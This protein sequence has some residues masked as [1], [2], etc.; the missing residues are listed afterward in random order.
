M[1]KRTIA[2][3]VM[4]VLGFS[5]INAP[6]FAASPAESFGVE[7]NI[8]KGCANDSDGVMCI[9]RLVVIIMS[10]CIG[11]LAVIGITVAGI[12]YLTAGGNED[13]TK[14]AKRRLY[15]IVIGL[16]AYVLIALL[17]GWLI[18]NFVWP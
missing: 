14:K 8:L 6:V 5:S 18:P 2:L 17:L 9:L 3:V 4:L 1:L 10:V 16:L 12:Q 7:A 11:V 13:K 15:E